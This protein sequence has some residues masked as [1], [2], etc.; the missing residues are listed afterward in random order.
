MSMNRKTILKS[1]R[2]NFPISKKVYDSSEYN[3][4]DNDY[5]DLALL[6]NSRSNQDTN[7]RKYN[8]TR[9]HNPR[10]CYFICHQ[11]DHLADN[12]NLNS[13]TN[14]TVIIIEVIIFISIN[15]IENINNIRVPKND[16]PMIDNNIYN[17][18]FIHNLDN[19]YNYNNKTFLFFWTFDSS[20]IEHTILNSLKFLKK[21]DK[22]PNEGFDTKSNSYLIM[23]NTIVPGSILTVK[24][25]ITL[26][27]LITITGKYIELLSMM[28]LLGDLDSGQKKNGANL[29]R[30]LSYIQIVN[31]MTSA[32]P[33]NRGVGGMTSVDV[34]M[35]RHKSYNSDNPYILNTFKQFKI[36]RIYDNEQK[37]DEVPTIYK[38]TLKSKYA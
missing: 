31:N 2:N 17:I 10:K 18:D 1:G 22:I 15:S 12:S 33:D 7:K 3:N 16:V 37:D 35:I 30:Y 36:H 8:S 29:S 4:E 26:Y 11:Q 5:M 34:K 20:T 21:L 6:F 19:I 14:I 27:D 13:S 25:L 23:N 24:T 28:D 32:I 9:K 38:M